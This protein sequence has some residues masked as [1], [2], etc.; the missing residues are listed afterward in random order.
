MPQQKGLIEALEMS[1]DIQRQLDRVLHIL[2]TDIEQV[3]LSK[4]VTNSDPRLS[5]DEDILEPEQMEELHYAQQE[6]FLQMQDM[7]S[8]LTERIKSANYR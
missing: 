8:K 2:R 4:A 5:H 3:H 7:V 1:R 6:D